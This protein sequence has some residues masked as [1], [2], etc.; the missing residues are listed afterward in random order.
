M[1]ETGK[2]KNRWETRLSYHQ[3]KKLA[4]SIKN[5]R[6][7]YLLPFVGE[8]RISDRISL[9]PL[10][11]AVEEANRRVIDANYGIVYPK[12]FEHEYLNQ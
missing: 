2:I 12:Q 1:T 9:K 11:Q 6:K 8:I 4:R 10:H 7:M 3:Q 5:A